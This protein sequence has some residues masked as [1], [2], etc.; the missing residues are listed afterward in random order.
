M[1]WQQRQLFLDGSTLLIQ[2]GNTC[3]H[4]VIRHTIRS[5]RLTTAFLNISSSYLQACTGPRTTRKYLNLPSCGQESV[6]L[7]FSL[8]GG[9]ELGPGV[10]GR[11]WRILVAVA[12]ITSEIRD[13]RS[14]ALPING[15]VS[16]PS[17][18]LR[19]GVR[20]LNVSS[21][22]DI[23]SGVSIRWKLRTTWRY[24]LRF[25]HRFTARRPCSGRECT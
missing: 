23:Y 19:L 11:G 7:E 22:N 5:R 3:I 8:R 16:P 10:G 18:N 6:V 24:R 12:A 13:V 2:R 4:L 14:R 17:N 9:A 15:K 25:L 21:R 20:T 1:R